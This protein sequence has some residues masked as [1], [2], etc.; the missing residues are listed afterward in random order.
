MTPVRPLNW[1]IISPTRPSCC[2]GRSRQR[3]P[4]CGERLDRHALLLDPG[5]VAEVEDPPAVLRVVQQL[6]GA[7]AEH[8]PAER[9]GCGDLV[10]AAGEVSRAIRARTLP[11]MLAL[12]G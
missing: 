6:I 11:Y 12:S 9:L 8:P 10:E 2:A 4:A 5:E 1:R 3:L 7:R